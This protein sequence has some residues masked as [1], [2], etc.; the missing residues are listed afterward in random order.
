M[1]KLFQ[2]IEVLFTTKSLYPVKFSKSAVNNKMTKVSPAKRATIYSHTVV[3]LRMCTSLKTTCQKV[4][5]SGWEILCINGNELNFVKTWP[6]VS[7]F[8]SAKVFFLANSQFY[9]FSTEDLTCNFWGWEYFLLLMFCRISNQ[10]G[11]IWVERVGWKR[12]TKCKSKKVRFKKGKK[13]VENDIKRGKESK[14]LMKNICACI[15]LTT[16]LFRRFCD[17]YDLHGI[18]L[19]IDFMLTKI[20]SNINIWILSRSRQIFS[21]LQIISL[22]YIILEV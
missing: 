20:L 10:F 7:N 16:L 15:Y 3:D 21:Y 22:L 9:T 14:Q 6:F 1:G 17:E 11:L 19:L 5:W 12:P 4:V 8:V 13:E 18:L 2:F